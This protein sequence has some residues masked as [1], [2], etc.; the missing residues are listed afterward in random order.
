MNRFFS[1][2]DAIVAPNFLKTAPGVS[3]DMDTYFS[4]GD[5]VGG[6]GNA[7]GLPALAL[8][9]GFGRDGMPCGFQLIAPAFEEAVVL[10]IG[11]AYQEK[12]AWHRERPPG[13]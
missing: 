5:P 6:M 2:Y 10:R 12:T 11:R 1:D 13:A 9:M 8:P 3:E 4:G 7:C